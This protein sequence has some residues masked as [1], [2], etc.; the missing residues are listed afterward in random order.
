MDELFDLFDVVSTL[1]D[2]TDLTD[3]ADTL[4]TALDGL[5]Y[6]DFDA[7]DLSLLDDLATFG[8]DDLV[9]VADSFDHV[10]AFLDPDLDSDY[11][12]W[13]S[14]DDIADPSAVDFGDVGQF[15]ADEVG[16]YPDQ[17][18][19]GLDGIEYHP[20]PNPDIWVFGSLMGRLPTSNCLTIRNRSIS[21]SIT[22][23]PT[24]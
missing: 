1:D 6:I 22:K 2:F 11:T 3:H 10:G 13:H 16:D 5:D 17:L 4:L 14:F 24:T 15:V 23:W 18:L 8:P 21:R 19:L 12:G 20:E 7:G 9:S